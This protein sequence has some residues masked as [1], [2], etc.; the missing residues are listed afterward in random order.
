MKQVFHFSL[1]FRDIPVYLIM[2]FMCF[3]IKIQRQNN[4]INSFLITSHIYPKDS[5]QYA[6]SNRVLFDLILY[7][8]INNFSV[9]S[10]SQYVN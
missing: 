9:M 5:N 6:K 8:P 7:V 2:H 3:E 10:G 1:L 4:L